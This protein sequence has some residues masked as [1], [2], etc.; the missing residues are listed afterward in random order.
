MTL[1]I[2]FKNIIFIWYERNV[3]SLTGSNNKQTI[4][5]IIEE[6]YKLHVSLFINKQS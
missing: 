4:E 1:T 2:C 6:Q 3:I 5:N